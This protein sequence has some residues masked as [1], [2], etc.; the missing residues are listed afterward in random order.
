[1]AHI[2]RRAGDTYTKRQTQNRDQQL[3]L[4]SSPGTATGGRRNQAG[5]GSSPKSVCVEDGRLEPM[6]TQSNSSKSRSTE[7]FGFTP[8]ELRKLRSLK[9]PAGIQKFLDDLPYN[10]RYD[11]RSPK[12]VLHD[13]V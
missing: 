2:A 4:H 10:L 5:C 13:R 1:M 11:A 8:S 3:A 9:T 6:T 12:K 7:S